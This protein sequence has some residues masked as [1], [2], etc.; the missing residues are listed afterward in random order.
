MYATDWNRINLPPLG[1][2]WRYGGWWRWLI[3]A[4]ILG[5]RRGALS[6]PHTRAAPSMPARSSA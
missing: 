3:L 5:R 4:L 1:L 2:S 6:S